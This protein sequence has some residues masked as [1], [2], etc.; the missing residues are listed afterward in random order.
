MRI[1]QLPDPLHEYLV[2]VVEKHAA[3]GIHPE[4]GLALSKLWEAVTRAVAV[5]EAALQKRAEEASRP[6]PAP[7]QA[8]GGTDYDER[9]GEHSCGSA[10]EAGKDEPYRG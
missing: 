3:S 10:P 9:T 2:H 8:C 4:E 6:A 7:C 5:D 1:I